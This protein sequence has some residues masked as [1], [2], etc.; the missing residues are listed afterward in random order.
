MEEKKETS[1]SRKV[2]VTK[3]DFNRGWISVVGVATALAFISLFTVDF[4]CRI[5]G[6]EPSDETKLTYLTIMLVISSLGM[7]SYWFLRP[8]VYGVIWRGDGMGGGEGQGS[9][10]FHREQAGP[11]GRP[12]AF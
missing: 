12:L 7:C 3:T 1:E 11:I 9:R 8:L 2:G 6:R 4:I 10:C 5:C